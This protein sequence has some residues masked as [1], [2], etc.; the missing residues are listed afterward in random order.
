MKSLIKFICFVYLLLISFNN[1]VISQE[2]EIIVTNHFGG[3]INQIASSE[4]NLF[5]CQSNA[6]KIASVLNEQPQILASSVITFN[7]SVI[8]GLGNF[9][10]VSYQNKIMSIDFSNIN[11]I[12]QSSVVSIG[13]STSDNI[14]SIFANSQ[15]I[16]TTQFNSSSRTGAI[17]VLDRNNFSVL[18][19]FSMV[20]KH[21][22]VINNKAYVI[23]GD[24]SM[25]TQ[26]Q[27][28]R[29]YDVT[30]P[31]NISEL[32]SIRLDGCTK[33]FVSGNYAYVVGTARK[34]I[35]IVDVT[36]PSNMTILANE[37][38]YNS[39]LSH[40]YVIG[41]YA[42]VSEFGRNF[43][44]IDVSNKSNPTELTKATLNVFSITAQAI[45]GSGTALRAFVLQG[46]S[47]NILNI[48]NPSNIVQY[49][50]YD[51][52]SLVTCSEI[53]QSNIFIG[54]GNSIWKAPINN[55]NS[56]TRW[57][58][59]NNKY[60]R[61][62]NN[63]LYVLSD[64][65]TGGKLKLYDISNINSPQEKGNYTS[66]SKIR[67]FSLL[68]LNS[69]LII[70]NTNK[71]EV[72]NCSNSNSPTK[73][74]EY[75]LTQNGTNLFI[76]DGN[77]NYVY[78]TYYNSTN[79]EKGFE[80]INAS[81]PDA[82]LKISNT[83]VYGI[84]YSIYVDKNTLYIGGYSSST[85]WFLQAFDI[86]NKN[87]P[88]LIAQI[89]ESGS[90]NENVL[91]IYAKDDFVLISLNRAGLRTYQL[92]RS[93]QTILSKTSIKNL[94]PSFKKTGENS[95]VNYPRDIKT[96]ISE[97][98]LWAYIYGDYWYQSQTTKYGSEGLYTVKIPKP[99]AA[100]S[101]V[102]LTMNIEPAIAAAN[103]CTVSPGVGNHKYKINTVVDL[104]ATP[105]T[106][107]GW[108]FIKWTGDVSGTSKSIS[109]TM[110]KD[111]IV[112]A[113]FAQ[114]VLTISGKK[115]KEVV[116]PDTFVTK[117]NIEMLPVNLTASEAS[118]WLVT[119][120]RLKSSGT[121]DESKDIQSIKVYRGNSLISTGVFVEDDGKPILHFDPVI[122]IGP[123]QTVSLKIEYEFKDLPEDYIKT[124]VKTFKLETQ[125]AI[126]TPVDVSEGQVIGKAES[127]YLTIARVYNSKKEGFVKIQDALNSPTTENGGE[128]SVCSGVYDESLELK[129]DVILKGIKG[130]SKTEI[131]SSHKELI[132][133]ND[134][135]FS[136][137]GFTIRSSNT[138]TRGIITDPTNKPY[139]NTRIKGRQIKNNIFFVG[140]ISLF[141]SDEC[142]ISNNNFYLLK[143]LEIY[144]K[145][146]NIESNLIDGLLTVR[147]RE[148]K[149]S[150]NTIKRLSLGR[151]FL[152]EGI[153]SYDNKIFDNIVGEADLS[154]ILGSEIFDNTF[155]FYSPGK[156]VALLIKESKD[157]RIY[158]NKFTDKYA[159]AIQEENLSRKNIY[160]DNTIKNYTEIGISLIGSMDTDIEENI[161]IG[162]NSN[163]GIFIKDVAYINIIN[164][165]IKQNSSKEGS[166]IFIQKSFRSAIYRNNIIDNCSGIKEKD[167][168][169]TRM[170]GNIISNSQCINTGINLSNSSPL[171]FGN[172]ISNNNGNG[173]LA[174]NGSNPIVNSN[175]IHGNS[176]F[177]INNTTAGINI[178]ATSNFWGSSA[179]PSTN[180]FSGAVNTTN[181][182]SSSVG[183]VSKVLKDTVY[184]I[185][186][187]S[188]SNFVF[189]QNFNKYDDELELTISE[190]KSWIKGEKSLSKKM[191]D[192]IGITLPIKI[193]V[194][195]SVTQ[196]QQNKVVVLSKSKTNPTETRKD[197]FYV[198]SYSPQ[199]KRIVIHPDS[200]TVVVGDSVLFAIEGFDQHNNSF[201][202]KP[203]WQS[204][205]GTINN[206]GLFKATTAGVATI[207]AKCSGNIESSTKIL[208]ANTAPQLA[209][210]NISPKQITID[211]NEYVLFSAN[212]NNQ[213][214]F[215]HSVGIKWSA[216]GGTI[217]SAGFYIAPSNPGTYT[218]TAQ[219]T[220]SQIKATATVLVKTP[221]SIK[222]EE[223]IN[224]FALMQNYPNPFNPVTKIV[225]KVPQ[226]ADGFR[227]SNRVIIK[228]YDVLGREVQT[229]VDEVK[230]PGTYEVEF[231]ASRLASGVYFY[232]MT[233][234][235]FVK[236]KKLL[237]LK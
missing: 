122:I 14:T 4:Q 233:C 86:S 101:E 107:F 121:G 141:N 30:N 87:N 172:T 124:E 33:V 13:N 75:N 5:L 128:C 9:A 132:K 127:D 155:N 96:S 202:E 59:T 234:G 153:T 32:G 227:A 106:N 115:E 11:N 220:I 133:L 51:Y 16:Y 203:S 231:N 140:E 174:A 84:P 156:S 126:A 222:D 109:L 182:L 152:S 148:N 213:F 192:S 184:I 78:C 216:N 89:V 90:S 81:N 181:W 29:V 142:L 130:A 61:A 224:E 186:G 185:P 19:S 41:N 196:N 28:L 179:G 120:L 24:A 85:E 46:G 92:D 91:D 180:S 108:F 206:D 58:T 82:L 161:I 54:D 123:G 111:K 226:I 145:S 71:L 95:K 187:S 2:Q 60:L 195:S 169:G 183:L 191:K 232:R 147:G 66:S 149:I 200:S 119:G 158:N 229:L 125:T 218:I 47:L 69:Y 48:S 38:G 118:G 178:N 26:T 138:L 23:T 31:A 207:T 139:S 93:S 223:I 116:C 198:F 15:Y 159:V 79:S 135:E 204:T 167:S 37:K 168:E 103:G 150:S 65:T 171:I 97:D 88:Q 175:N 105:N 143:N 189:Y 190:E 49:N 22:Q 177:G 170:Y 44:I 83:S 176:L 62:S 76:P 67:A 219:D 98:D 25:G 10:F 210:I 166:G 236:T 117:K 80:I 43:V 197:S 53:Y 99:F 157:N 134:K 63:T 164:N 104:T 217:N 221:T 146:N 50:P 188:D 17:C 205:L 110:D 194:P 165:Q 68:G 235:G 94:S 40:I 160:I 102:N 201:S 208:M 77:E 131:T 20:S 52:T 7:P 56:A 230:S 12:T 34:G 112:T 214:G 36:N 144:G 151:S 212:G 154:H 114:V 39:S 55:I 21:I 211:I 209:S 72:I 137:I 163:I 100:S 237:F 215:P 173:I 27:M 136:L 1:F 70:D 18:G 57:I 8:F 162:N 74:S 35:T 6:V 3:R 193:E 45:Y 199:L 228:V 129:K 73:R 113:N 42:Y 225:F 64:E